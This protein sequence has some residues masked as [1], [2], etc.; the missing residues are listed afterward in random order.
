MI[1]VPTS[2]TENSS[3]LIDLLITNNPNIIELC[4]VRE[5]FLNVNIRY[6]SPTYCF[7]KS[8]KTHNSIFT[9]KIFLYK[10]GNYDEYRNKL[11]TTEWD[12]LINDNITVDQCVTNVT[13]KIIKVAEET[14]PNKIIKV[15]KNDLP[16][17]TNEIKQMIRK[18]NRIR[19]KAKKSNNPMHWY[20]FRQIRNKIVN[21][22]K[23]AKDKHYDKTTQ[24]IETQ[25]FCS[26]DWW[27]MVKEVSCF[28]NKSSELDVL[29]NENGIVINDDEEKANLLNNYFAIQSTMNTADLNPPSLPVSSDPNLESVTII[30]QDIIDV[31]QCLDTNKACG[32]DSINPILL[33]EAANEL[34]YPL[35]K[36][37]NLSLSTCI[38]PEQW[39]LAHIVPVFKKD[40]PQ[41]IENYRPI[42]LLSILSKVFERCIFKYLHNYIVSNDLLSPHQSGFTRGDSTINQL[43]YITDEISKSLDLGKEVRAIFFDISKAFDRVW[44]LGLLVK[45]ENLGIKGNLLKWIKSY[46]S[47]RNQRVILNGKKS[48][49]LSI[50]S[51]VPQ[52]S[53]LGPIFF[54]IFINDIVYEIGCT[55]KLFADD[56]SIYITIENPITDATILNSD[57]KKIHEWATKWLVN[58]N[59]NKTKSLLISRK[60]IAVQH[61]PLNMNN[62]TIQEVTQHRHLGLIL[63]NNGNWGQHIDTILNKASS[64]LNILRSL[65]FKLQR[66]TLMIMY[67]S[68]VRPILEYCDIIWDNCPN[69]YKNQLEQINLEAGRIIS[70]A[71]KYTSTLSIY[72]ETGLESLEKRREK[73]KVIQ[74]FKIIHGLTPSYLTSIIPPQNHDFHNYNTRHSDRYINIHCRTAHYSNSFVPSSIRLWNELPQRVKEISS[75]SK[76]KSVLSHK[77]KV[78]EYYNVGDRRGQILH[79][80]LRMKCSS[81]KQ[82][83]YLCNLESD[84]YCTCGKIESNFHY[85]LDCS[86]YNLLRQQ[87]I[88]SINLD[89]NTTLLLFGD[90]KLSYEI[91]CKIFLNVQKFIVKSKRFT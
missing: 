91:N 28:T 61:P 65:K 39:K 45:I 76:F 70:G 55:I 38:Y 6:H 32:P 40:D 15:N 16:W 78:P 81:L 80:R 64:R 75:L 58:F 88:H 86:K 48:D 13:N 87:Y 82:H 25:Q 84:P 66:K 74:I 2:F 63:T 30:N 11:Q 77:P 60:T 50:N 46:L 34:C 19:K 68:F 90:E 56:T 42:S 18:R 54:L 57:L 83:L 79:T 10:Y 3:T 14:I 85:L 20:K 31:L 72:N 8:E 33:K 52:G 67:F 17:I 69:Y 5:P 41:K 89:I 21:K 7:L 1:N 36:L 27:K 73:H 51:G 37:F 9:R 12:E 4:E 44:H 26:K 53:I 24:K 59:P 43:L 35:C 71:T 29:I 62:T 47:G 49:V 23:S 22:L